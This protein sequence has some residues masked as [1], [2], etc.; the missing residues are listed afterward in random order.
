MYI[1]RV[2]E[3]ERDALVK[4]LITKWD[5]K[6]DGIWSYWYPLKECRRNDVIAFISLDYDTDEEKE[7]II[8]NYILSVGDN[9]IYEMNEFGLATYVISTESLYPF[10]PNRGEG[11][12][13]WFSEH[14]KWIIYVSHDN[15]IT[16]GGRALIKH[17]KDNWRNWKSDLYS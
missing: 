7:Q 14:M 1:R 5:V 10:Y 11:E 12:T 8:K 2:A 17:I 15:T 6:I 4:S 13:I 16:F 9:E 3:R